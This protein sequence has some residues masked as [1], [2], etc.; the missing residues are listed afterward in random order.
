MR[1]QILD[2][3]NQHPKHYSALIK[4]NAVLFNWVKDNSLIQ[5]DHLPTMIYSAVHN[6]DPRCNA[7][8]CRK[9]SRWS[10]GLVNCGPA[11]SCACTAAN[12][13]ARV[14]VSKLNYTDEKKKSIE[15]SRTATMLGK[16]GVRYNSQRQSVK[17]VLKKSKL[18]Q[19]QYSVLI[20]SEWLRREYVEAKRSAVDIAAEL[21]CHDSAVRRYVALHG[22]EVRNY[23]VRS[24]EE[25]K[26][27]RWLNENNIA[28]EVCNRSLLAGSELDIYIPSRALAIEVNGLLY[29]SYNPNA[30]HIARQK[31]ERKRQEQRNRHLDKTVAAAAAGVQL[32]QFTDAVINNSWDIVTNIIGSKLGLHS[33]IGARRCVVK[34]VDVA[35]QKQFFNRVHLQKYA[36]SKHAYGLYHNDRLVQCITIGQSRYRKNELEII[37][38]ASELHTTVSGGLSRLLKHITAAHPN[39]VITTYCDR[40]ISNGSGYISAGFTIIDHTKP[41]YFWTDGRDIIS[42][43]RSQRQQLAKWLVGYNSAESESV[44]M[45]R[46]G[47][48]RYWNTGNIVLQYNKQ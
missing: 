6:I 29:H 11:K 19:S 24:S 5:C 23:S 17:S 45:F 20:D 43:Y 35:S 38:F 16:Y 40:D 39:A 7:G 10:Q 2:L 42:R 4:R 41:G 8:K 46:A 14:S 48:L 27:C 34:Q 25:H 36:A 1:D 22:F 31:N 12:I 9:L 26:I 30:F 44:N 21:G 15:S 37:R 13:S 32:L 18:E 47:Y 33:V 28:H 3:I